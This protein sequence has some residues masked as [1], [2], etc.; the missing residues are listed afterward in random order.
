MMIFPCCLSVKSSVKL[1]LRTNGVGVLIFRTYRPA[2]LGRPLN[3][4]PAVRRRVG[5]KLRLNKMSYIG[6]P[7]NSIFH[8]MLFNSSHMNVLIGT[9]RFE[10]DGLLTLP[11]FSQYNSILQALAIRSQY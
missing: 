11:L 1:V 3:R 7:G 6:L 4:L 2:I 10:A 8:I 5:T 9:G